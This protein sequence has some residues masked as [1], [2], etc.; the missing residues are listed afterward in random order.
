ME[1]DPLAV[2]KLKLVVVNPDDEPK[3]AKISVELAQDEEKNLVGVL[4]R[5]HDVFS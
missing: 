2:D 5:N 4:Q 3:T 1:C